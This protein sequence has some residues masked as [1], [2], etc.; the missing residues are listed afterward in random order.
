ME[1]QEREL[2]EFELEKFRNEQNKMLDSKRGDIQK[3]QAEKRKIQSEYNIELDQLKRDMDRR[4]EKEKRELQDQ[5]NREILEIE[6]Q[7]E[8]KYEQQLTQMKHEME[9]EAKNSGSMLN[10]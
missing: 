5:M 4:F 6:R 7:E 9:Q 2:Y 3:L 1:D 8:R 10:Q